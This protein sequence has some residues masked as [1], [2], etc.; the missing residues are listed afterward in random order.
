AREPELGRGPGKGRAG[1]DQSEER[2]RGEI[3]ALEYA[4][5][6]PPDLAREPV[7]LV[8]VEELIIG[9]HLRRIARRF[10][11]DRGDVEF[12]GADVENGIVELARELERPE[13]RTCS[14]MASAEAGGGA[15]GPR[16]VMVASR[17]R[18]D[19]PGS[20]ECPARALLEWPRWPL[21]SL[22]SAAAR[23]STEIVLY[24]TAS[25]ERSRA[26]GLSAMPLVPAGRRDFAANSR[27]RFPTA[28]SS[29]EAGTTSSTSRQSTARLPLMPSS[30]VQNTSAR[31]RRTLR[32]SVTR[33]SP[34]VPGSTASSGSSG[35]DT[36]EEPSSI[37]M[38][39]S[40]A[41]ASS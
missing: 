29:L 2:G 32:L 37:S 3:D 26:S 31:S 35:S 33:G 10:E 25:A 18:A 38:M 9:E 16:K 36:A 8:G 11:D 40:A 5:P 27:A 20:G 23:S 4:L 13:L 34:P 15:C 24:S 6:K 19:E 1:R 7:I 12:V 14:T 39:W 41:S 22:A 30:V 28:S 21:A 17:A